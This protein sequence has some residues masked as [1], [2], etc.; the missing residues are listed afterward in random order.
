[1]SLIDKCYLETD[2]TAKQT[3]RLFLDIVMQPHA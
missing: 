2:Q 3:L 1:M